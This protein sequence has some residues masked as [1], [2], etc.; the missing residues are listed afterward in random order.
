MN[1]VSYLKYLRAHLTSRAPLSAQLHRE[2]LS[3]LREHPHLH[4]VDQH[5]HRTQPL[6]LDGVE[7][8][9]VPGREMGEEKK[10][11]KKKK[12][13]EAQDGGGVAEVGG[14]GDERGC[15]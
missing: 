7:Q 15:W 6:L 1:F 3:V 11:K 9:Q 2:G 13:S 4:R 5:R 10:K 12:Q 14:G 8:N